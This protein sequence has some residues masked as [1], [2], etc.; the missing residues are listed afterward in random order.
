MEVIGLLLHWPIGYEFHALISLATNGSR[1][2][3][4]VHLNLN[5]DFYD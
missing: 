4:V 5:E 3:N 2:I 1:C